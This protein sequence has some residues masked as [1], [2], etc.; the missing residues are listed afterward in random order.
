MSKDFSQDF[1]ALFGLPARFELETAQLDERYR[2][3]ASEV[4]PDRYAH[5]GEAEKRVA[6]MMAT[7]V[8]EAYQTLKQP[9]A[10][11]RYLLQLNGVD[12]QEETNTAMP[13]AFLM[14]Q[15]EWR[16]AIMEAKAGRDV[17]TLEKLARDLRGEVT[18]LSEEMRLALDETRDLTGA[19]VLLRKW[20]FL[21]KL[22]QE[23][24]DAIE[25]LLY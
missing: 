19:A 17:D 21:E 9:L 6:L 7:R 25:T 13:A 3:A 24:G 1:F 18:V 10:R 2:A 15:M 11:A 12:A 16:E 20:R 14:E 4:H 5:A 23:I 22:E 8:N